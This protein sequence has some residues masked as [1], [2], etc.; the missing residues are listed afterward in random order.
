M[1][2]KPRYRNLSWRRERQKW[3]TRVHLTKHPVR[4]DVT[5]HLGYHESDEAAAR[6]GDFVRFLLS[7]YG[8]MDERIDP[9]HTFDGFPPDSY[10]FP[11]I[12]EHLRSQEI[13]TSEQIEEIG[14]WWGKVMVYS[15][16]PGGL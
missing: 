14:E 7:R 4:G 11:L 9:S 16:K 3:E 13:F 10:P 8:M 12:M 6:V 15:R 1:S 2:K 5:I